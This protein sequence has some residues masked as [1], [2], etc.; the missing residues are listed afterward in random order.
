MRGIGGA[1][2][3]GTDAIRLL[4]GR[5]FRVSI[6]SAFHRNSIGTIYATMM[7]LVELG[8]DGW[9]TNPV[10]NSGNWQHE[11]GSLDLS[12][13]ELY[14]A[15]LELIPRYLKE[16]SPLGI[17]LGGFFM[18]DKG[19]KEYAIPAKKQ[20]NENAPLCLSARNTLYIAA[21]G[22]LLPCMPLAGLHIQ[23]EMPSLY[24]MTVAQALSASLYLERIET[25]VSA[26]MEHNPGCAS[27]EHRKVCGGGCRASAL[28][29]HNDYLGADPATCAFF[30]GGYEDKIRRAVYPDST[31]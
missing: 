25:P 19:S 11:D 30:K 22:K 14:A 10:A 18:C 17:M 12:V 23:E 13:E 4:H 6:E 2:K 8:V 9:K 3:M 15:Y 24:D 7:L 5:G 21:D 1:E 27:C 16:G 28:T 26:L 20:G 31:P 29:E